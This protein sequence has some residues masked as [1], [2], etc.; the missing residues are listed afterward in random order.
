MTADELKV[1]MRAHRKWC[2][3][4]EGGSRANLR[5]ADLR[6]ADLMGTVLKSWSAYEWAWSQECPMRS[7]G[8]R[9]LVLGA[10]TADSPTIGG[11]EYEADKLYIAPHFSACPVTKC[12]PGL[13][14]TC[15]PEADPV[16]V[17][18]SGTGKMLVAFWLDEAVCV[19]KLR[20]P[21]FYALAK[22]ED[23]DSV[24]AEMMEGDDG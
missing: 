14:V 24:T 6:G 13:Y 9:T 23:F 2:D 19:E 22:R 18:G 7:I 1:V 20:V 12:H 16:N 10:R 8:C 17:Y 11:E 5:D 15:G 21:R 4:E 3:G